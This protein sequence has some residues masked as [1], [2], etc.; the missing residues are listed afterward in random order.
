MLDPP[1]SDTTLFPPKRSLSRNCSGFNADSISLLDNGRK[2]RRLLEEKVALY[3][4]R[5]RRKF[6]DSWYL[7]GF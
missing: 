1:L 7:M 3:D 2:L 5:H 6:K 4:L